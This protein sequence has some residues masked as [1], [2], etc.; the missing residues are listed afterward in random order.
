MPPDTPETTPVAEPTVATVVVLDAHVPPDVVSLSVVVAPAHMVVTPVMGAIAFTIVIAL[1]AVALPQLFV[2]MYMA[3]SLPAVTP[4][5]VPPLV[6]V[7]FPLLMLH[8]PPLTELD[9]VIVAPVNTDVAPLMVPAPGTAVTV[10]FMV[11][12]DAPQLPDTE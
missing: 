9:N 2:T 10:T 11:A 8:E 7:A 1:V 4:V 6:M 12:T 5:T 3:V